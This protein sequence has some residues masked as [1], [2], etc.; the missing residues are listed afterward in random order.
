MILNDAFYAASLPKVTI[1]SFPDTPDYCR[2]LGGLLLPKETVFLF[3]HT[4]WKRPIATV[5]KP[6]TEEN[7]DEWEGFYEDGGGWEEF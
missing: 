2:C 5:T 6:V 7:D 3:V 4:V 1:V